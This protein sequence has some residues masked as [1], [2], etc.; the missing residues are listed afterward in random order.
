MRQSLHPFGLLRDGF[1]WSEQSSGRAYFIALMVLICLVGGWLYLENIDGLSRWLIFPVAIATSIAFVAFCGHQ[2]RRLNDM[3][4]PGWLWWLWLIPLTAPFIIISCVFVSGGR[5][6]SAGVLLPVIS[7]LATLFFALLIILRAFWAPTMLLPASMKPALLPGDVVLVSLGQYRPNQG[8][9]VVF[10]RT[11]AGDPMI[12][13]AIGL[14]GD[15]VELIEGVL[16]INDVAIDAVF[17]TTHQEVLQRQGPSEILPR[18]QN[19]AVAMGAQCRKPQLSETLPN[20][21]TIR[22][23]NIGLQRSDDMAAVTVPPD[24][25]FVLG[26][27]RDAA[28]DSRTPQVAGGAGLVPMTKIRGR[29][30]RVVFSTNGRYWASFWTWRQGR[31][32]MA[33]E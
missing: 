33:I 21:A 2:M 14:P 23:L 4:W 12:S 9:I 28:I 25:I 31:Y 7:I 8:D 16:H 6:F 1:N 29:A 10:D 18:C 19:G 24:H 22:V 13:R 3:G 32:F 5:R 26:D 20:G 27:N 30:T 11:G 17:E 15:K